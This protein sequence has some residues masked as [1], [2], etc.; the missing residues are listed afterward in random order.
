MGKAILSVIAG[1][2]VMAIIVMGS[3]TGAY[4]AMGADKAFEAGS[5]APSKLW[6]V[7]MI[8]VGIVAAL[9]GGWVCKVI[10]KTPTPP[11]VLAGIV[12]V[13]GLVSAAIQMNKAAPTLERT[14]TVSNMEA[15]QNAQTPAWAAF[16]Q[17]IIGAS[18]VM[19]GAGMGKQHAGG[20]KA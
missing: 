10:C 18:G 1:Y 14:A 6:L 17:A 20:K 2:V 8:I 11:K 12:L 4:F 13:L 15:M 19:V 7:I 16:L 3:L 9:A 5:W